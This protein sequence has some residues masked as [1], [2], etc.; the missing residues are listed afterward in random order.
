MLQTLNNHI[1]LL[2]LLFCAL[3]LLCSALLF[4]LLIR[5]RRTEKNTDER[6]QHTEKHISYV[7]STLENRLRDELA[8]QEASI[9]A[10]SAQSTRDLA[11]RTDALGGRMDAF[12]QTQEARLHRITATL[13]EKLTAN[14]QRSEKLRETL[15]LGME[16]LQKENAEKLEQMRQTVDEKLHETLNKRLGESFS[17]VNERLEQVYKG[18]GEMQTLASGVGDLKKVLTNVKT[19]G[20]WGEVQLGALL[21]QMLAPGQ[22]TE[23][24][25]VVPHGRERVEYAVILPGREEGQ[26]V[27]LPIDSKFPI[28]A[29]ERLLEASEVG[30]AQR[31]AVCGSEL[32]TSIRTEAKRIASKYIALPYTTDFAIMF[33]ATEGLYAEALRARGLMEDIQRQHHILIAGPSTLSALLSSLQLGFKTLAIEKRSAEVSQ[34]LSAVKGEFL[35]FSDLLDQTQQRLRQAGDTIEKAAKKTR[36]INRRLR[37]V[38]TLDTTQATSMLDALD[39]DE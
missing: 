10:E 15:S 12:G 20:I 11:Q 35:R 13:D 2:L 18:L 39:D 9:L 32:Q 29:Y 7:A 16:R 37:A 27:L 24:V 23:N 5:Q 19:R 26:T 4:I 33:L 22:Y 31:V 30:D 8:R 14:D 25:P 3:L 21:E 17:L 1:G 38:E 34:L 28:E 6:Y 36:A